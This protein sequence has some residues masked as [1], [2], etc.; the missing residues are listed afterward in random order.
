MLESR[1]RESE[2][3]ERP[4]WT[5]RSDCES[6]VVDDAWSSSAVWF[7][8]IYEDPSEFAG[9]QQASTRLD[10][11]GERTSALSNRVT[12]S[13]LKLS[14]AMARPASPLPLLSPSFA[15]SLPLVFSTPAPGTTT[16]E[17]DDGG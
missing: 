6:T 5:E 9:Q 10:K 16:C 1:V 3:E 14:R 17:P 8:V 15:S 2:R 11:Q 7:W 4:C 13:M 12:S